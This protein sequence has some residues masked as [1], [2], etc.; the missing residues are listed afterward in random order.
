MSAAVE[1]DPFDNRWF[2]KRKATNCIDVL[3]ALAMAIGAATARVATSESVYEKLARAE[4]RSETI[5][6]GAAVG[7][8]SRLRRYGIWGD[9]DDDV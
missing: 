1:S 5:D 8:R 6:A 4:K 2:S 3:V 9:E 7:F